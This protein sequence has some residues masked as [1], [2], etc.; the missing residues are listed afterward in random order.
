L[1]INKCVVGAQT[2]NID[3]TKPN[4]RTFTANIP[5]RFN[6][7]LIN[8]QTIDKKLE[9]KINEINLNQQKILAASQANENYFQ[10]NFN[11]EDSLKQTSN[12]ENFI[13]AESA[14]SIESDCK[15]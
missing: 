12:L 1:S 8:F 13:V 11:I 9:N 4:Q 7:N 2:A 5:K 14:R 10:K 15:I 3:A 6:D